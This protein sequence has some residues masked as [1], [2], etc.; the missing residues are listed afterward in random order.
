M[1]PAPKH[2]REGSAAIV[3][4]VLSWARLEKSSGCSSQGVSE[5][6]RAARTALERLAHTAESPLS[7][8][9]STLGIVLIEDDH[10]EI[11]Q[12][13]DSIIV[14]QR[15]DSSIESV[16]PPERGEYINET[17]F[18]TSDNWES[19]LRISSL[20]VEQ[21][22]AVAASTDGLQFKILQNVRSGAAYVPFFE[23]LFAWSL[24]EDATDEGILRF[25]DNLEDQSG[26]DKTLLVAVKAASQQNQAK[27]A[28]VDRAE[29][30]IPSPPQ[31]PQ[32]NEH[33]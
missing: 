24:H 12:V 13:G 20:P 25:I 11:G 19:E 29:K 7:E 28:Q 1:E 2:A 18:V 32:A 16:V 17:S 14:I 10:I 23:D 15:N 6:V 27:R 4:A 30:G 31:L 9:A 8:Y 21:I 33:G 22:A 3:E 5:A 26:D